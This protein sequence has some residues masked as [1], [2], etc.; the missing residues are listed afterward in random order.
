M[1]VEGLRVCSD[2][3]GAHRIALTMDDSGLQMHLTKGSFTK[4][5][6]AEPCRYYS[7]KTAQTDDLLTVWLQFKATLW[8]PD[9]GDQGRARAGGGLLHS[10]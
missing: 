4:A 8:L 5:T 10:A 1:L 2:A 3:V 6:S 9:T 7:G